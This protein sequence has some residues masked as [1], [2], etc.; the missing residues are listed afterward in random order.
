MDMCE[1]L[2]SDTIWVVERLT[3][4]IESEFLARLGIEARVVFTSPR[5]KHKP[6]T[7]A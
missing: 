4:V 1:D 7:V 6:E 3:H 5:Q 2:F